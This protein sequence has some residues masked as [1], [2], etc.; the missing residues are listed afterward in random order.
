MNILG[1]EPF[2]TPR[3]TPVTE[4]VDQLIEVDWNLVNELAARQ[5]P[6]IV[7]LKLILEADRQRLLLAD[8]QARARLDGSALYRWNGLE[9]EVPAGDRIRSAAGEFDDWT[10]SVNFSVPLGLRRERALLRQQQLIIRR[11]NAN[12]Q[13]GLL[14]TQ[15]LLALSLRNLDQF[16]AQYE[17]FIS[18]RQ[19]ARENLDLQLSRYNEGVESFIVVLQA[20]VDWGNSVSSQAQSLSQYNTELAVLELQTGTILESHG[21]V[22]FEERFQSIGPL[23]R[24]GGDRCYPAALPPSDQVSRY[25]AGDRPSEEYFDLEDPVVREPRDTESSRELL[26]EKAMEEE[27]EFS[28]EADKPLSDQQIEDLLREEADRSGWLPKFFR[29]RFRR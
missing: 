15:Y 3:L 20:I 17:R 24:C 2:E 14:Q 12:L 5:R 28:E 29:K 1:L 6:D 23:G 18:V 11:D 9:G 19:A 4:M 22:F 26:D 21:I 8:N 7:E 25:Q 10:L 16:Y 27:P 13:Q